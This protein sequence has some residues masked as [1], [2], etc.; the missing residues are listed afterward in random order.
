MTL[1]TM[2][3]QYDLS[4]ILRCEVIHAMIGIIAGLS[5]TFFF[6]LLYSGPWGA[7]RILT[8]FGRDK[9]ERFTFYSC[10]LVGSSL[11]L[12]SHWLADIWELGW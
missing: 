6:L 9:K 7:Y 1:E 12:T 10:L 3:S 2:L 5:F 8:T 11:A 4:Y